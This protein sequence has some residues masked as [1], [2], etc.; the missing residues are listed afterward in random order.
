MVSGYLFGGAG[1]VVSFYMYSPAV[2]LWKWLKH[3]KEEIQFLVK[4]LSCMYN[5]LNFFSFVIAFAFSSAALG[6]FPYGIYYFCL[7]F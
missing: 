2:G 3:F 4:P 6:A 1:G 5:Q 7:V